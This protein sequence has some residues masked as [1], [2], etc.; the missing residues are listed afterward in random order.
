MNPILKWS[1][2]AVLAGVAA[3]YF[4][5]M[6]WK[7]EPVARVVLKRGRSGGSVSEDSMTKRVRVLASVG[8]LV[9]LGA[10]GVAV[11]RALG[12]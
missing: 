8:L 10:V 9:A 4:G 12:A 6:V 3:A 1:M 2:I 11:W 5:L 7:S